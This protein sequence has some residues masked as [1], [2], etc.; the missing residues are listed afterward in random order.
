MPMA[1]G[2]GRAA[3][4]QLA[5]AWDDRWDRVYVEESG[6]PRESWQSRS[7]ATLAAERGATPA[8]TLV[9]LAVAD[10]FRTRF[11]VQ[12]FN[13]DIDEVADLLNDRRCVLGLSDAGAHSDQLCDAVFPSHLLGTWVRDRQR[14]SLE[15]AVWRLSGQPAAVM[16]IAGRGLVK[17]GLAA[18]LVAFDPA[19]VGV[20]PLERVHDLP[21]GCERIV[22]RSTGIE[23]VWV[24]G[25]PVRL[26]DKAVDG[27]EPGRILEARR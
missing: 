4:G 3:I 7:M 2:G 11:E 27:P 17:E 25:C 19:T 18:D 14:L 26:D 8:S 21:Q 9:D 6:L 5:D 10:G 22:G 23:H 1:P 20:L 24:N 13:D 12:L 15:A 16:R